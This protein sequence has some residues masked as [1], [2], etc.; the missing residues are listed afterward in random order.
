M[1]CEPHTPEPLAPTP[2]VSSPPSIPLRSQPE[3]VAESARPGEEP[4]ARA[5][6]PP[7]HRLSTCRALT[8]SSLTSILEEASLPAREKRLAAG[9]MLR[10]LA[11]R[12]RLTLARARFTHAQARWQAALKPDPHAADPTDDDFDPDAFS[13]VN[14]AAAVAAYRL[15]YWNGFN[16]SVYKEDG[17]L[18][19]AAGAPQAAEALTRIKQLWPLRDMLPPE[20]VSTPTTV[21]DMGRA[22]PIVPAA[23][24]I[25]LLTALASFFALNPPA[26]LVPSIAA[27]AIGAHRAPLPPPTTPPL[28]TLTHPTYDRSVPAARPK[29]LVAMSGGVD[30]SVAAALLLQ[31]GYDVVGC[32]M[33]LGSPGESLDELLPITSAAD[34]GAS[35]SSCTPAKIGHQGCCSINDA[36]DARLVAAKLG[37]PFYVVNFKKD[38][39]RII[40]YFVDAYASGRTPNPCVRCNDWLK[41]GKLR[42]YARQI[43]APFVASGHYAR[44]EHASPDRQPRLLRGIDNDKDQSY[45]L[46]GVPRDELPHML[47]PIGGLSKPRVREI[48]RELGLPVFDKPDSQEICFVPDNDYAGLV[49]RRSPSAAQA[50][51]QGG[52]ILDTSGHVVGRH[53]GQHRFTLGQRRGVGVALGHPIYVVGKD[54]HANTITVGPPEALLS[55]GCTAGEANWLIPEPR[56]GA[57]I[58]CDI[59]YRYNT[60]PVRGQARVLEPGTGATPS[61]RA[62]RFEAVFHSRQTA[63]A[64]GQAVVL[65]EPGGGA[66]VIGGGW[67]ESTS[68]A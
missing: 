11:H 51:A 35:A 64:P 6:S 38:F 53:A 36:A 61:G 45:V 20:A 62:G 48:A 3:G 31:Q 9:T 63:V 58:D 34:A 32:F 40:D 41:F 22:R 8:L 39:G 15:G 14:P 7:S 4:P 37:V 57:W 60:P 54:A 1:S 46:F 18:G 13:F 68:A 56:P 16:G 49:E 27:A 19:P 67:I 33:R 28:S 66:P 42:D 44:V 65:Y 2:S 5:S 24:L 26:P 17:E 23:I 55:A 12:E 30:S 43:G 25:C 50:H 10:Y 59:K 47:L 29:V 52:D 21:A